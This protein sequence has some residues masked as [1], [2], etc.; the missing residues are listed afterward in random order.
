MSAV[1]FAVAA[2]FLLAPPLGAQTAE[3]A[4]VTA[5]QAFEMLQKLAGTWEGKT[6]GEGVPARVVYRNA[7]NGSVLMETLFPG[8]PHE[9]ISMY[10]RDGQDL[11]M[12]H[13]CAAGNQPRM[14]FD[15]KQ[16]TAQTLV[17][18]F[19]GGTNFDP[20]KDGHIHSGRITFSGEH[21]IEAAWS[22]WENGKLGHDKSFALER[23][24]D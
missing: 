22:W 9:M 14:R 8:T 16:S 5:T 7:A 13:Y 3:V 4:G 11:V 10:H 2:F 20:K 19:T 15:P 24:R 18:E 21:T 23:M 12:T 6:G 1:A 17:F